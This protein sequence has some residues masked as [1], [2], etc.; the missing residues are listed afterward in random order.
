MV[1]QHVVEVLDDH[2]PL[3]L[4]VE[5]NG[6]EGPDEVAEDVAHHLEGDAFVVVA[7]VVVEPLEVGQRQALVP[8]ERLEDVEQEVSFAVLHDP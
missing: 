3:S 7:V 2:L 6:D 5:L 1:A 8:H 4:I